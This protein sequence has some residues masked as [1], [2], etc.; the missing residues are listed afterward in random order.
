[1]AVWLSIALGGSLGSL[2]RYGVTRAVESRAVSVF[3]YDTL[4]VNLT[5]CFFVAV[6]IGALV[7]RHHAPA[8]LRLGLVV[9]FAGAYTTFSAFAQ[10]SYDLALARGDFPG[11]LFLAGLVLAILG[12]QGFIFAL[13]GEYLGRLQRDVEGRPLYTVGAELDTPRD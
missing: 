6:V 5:G 3:P 8:W 7:D 4:V 9:G 13:V 12:I 1:M 10:D 11:Q 2:A